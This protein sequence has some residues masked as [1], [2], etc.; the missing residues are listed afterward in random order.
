[1]KWAGAYGGGSSWCSPSGTSLRLSG[2]K[3]TIIGGVDG[4]DTA[5]SMLSALSAAEE[6]E[7]EIVD[8]V[9]ERSGCIFV[10]PPLPKNREEGAGRVATE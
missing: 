4:R 1:M 9:R 10:A 2:G 7:L 6:D 8:I 3:C 5:G